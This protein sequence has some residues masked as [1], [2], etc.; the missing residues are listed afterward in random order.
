MRYAIFL[1]LL[2]ALSACGAPPEQDAAVQTSAT[3]KGILKPEMVWIEGGQFNMG[4][5]ARYP[6]EGPPREVE[7]E[8]FWISQAEVTN[9]EFAKFVAATGYRTEAERDPPALPGAPPEMLQPG[10]AVFRV[11]TPDNRNWWAWV[12][13]ANW[14]NPSGPQSAIV[15]RDRDP[16]VQV[17]YQDALAFAQWA[18]LSLP[19]EEQ[20]EFAARAGT[21]A[22]SEPKDTSGNPTANYY[23]GV[24]PARDKGE[25]GFTSRAPVGCF[26]ANAFGLHDMI[27][28]VWEWTTNES[29]PASPTNVIKGGSF[30][31]AANYCARYRPAARQF[32]ER[33]LGTDHIGFRLVDNSRAA[34]SRTP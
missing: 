20:W 21:A 18:G 2:V 12:P 28:N 30:L 1:P 13:G 4:E 29:R 15:G 24:F 6:E 5:D 33:E 25:D 7:V 19:S 31:C 16:V 14:R 27:G 3:C 8:G 9:A 17:T 23:Q 11:P 10:S 32:Q 22:L 34:P 26:N